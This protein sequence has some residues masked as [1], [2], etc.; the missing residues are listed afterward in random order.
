M[1]FVNDVSSV[2]HIPSWIDHAAADEDRLGFA[3]TIFP[4]FLFIIGLS[5]PFAINQRIHKGHTTVSILW[6]IISRSAALIIMGF[7]HVNLESYSHAALLPYAVWIILVTIA[8]FFIWL[9]YPNHISK[10]IRNTLKAIGIIIL[11][12]MA[13]LY[14][15]GEGE[16]L[17]DME[18]SWWG[19]LGI[20]GWAY[21]VCSI[22]FVLLN[23]KLSSL[24]IAFLLL[25]GINIATH[26]GVMPF[27]INL[28]GDASSVS[29]IMAGVITSLF[30][31]K[32]AGAEKRKML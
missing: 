24:V 27:H 30:Y 6:Y 16:E 14:K 20:I 26:L 21:L 8:F 5:I 2:H 15:G 3:D 1:I 11:L 18:A 32:M 19:I 9:H 28:I 31:T 4:A 7:F 10:V 12:V 23:G 25:L 22:L 13:V 17:H 29:L